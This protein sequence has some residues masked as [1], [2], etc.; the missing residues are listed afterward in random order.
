[1]RVAI[2]EDDSVTRETLKLLL[3]NEPQIESVRVFDSGESLL[4]SLDK[5]VAD[6]LL[7][8]LDL[9]GMHGTELIHKVKLVR[10]DLDML[11]YTIY[12]D[13]ENVF[14]AIKAGASG[15]ILKGRSAR[16]LIES[17]LVL[18]QGGAPMSPRIARKVI[19]EFQKVAVPENPLSPK[20]SR[21]IRFIEEGLTYNIIAERLNISPHTVHN[22]IRNI[23]V[24]LHATN[25]TDA[26]NCA[27]R[28]GIL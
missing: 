26:L 23:Y 2:V 22:H 15:Y 4:E 24:K 25:R 17:L 20:E 18:E 5:V 1:M 14:A 7:V 12:E 28:I 16:D 21:I 27:R 8:D 9:P 3:E 10:P 19:G 13:R 11:V 6:V